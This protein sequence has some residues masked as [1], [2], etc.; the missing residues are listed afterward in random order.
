[1][2]PTGIDGR[3]QSGTDQVFSLLNVIANPE[4]YAKKLKAL[5]DATAEHKKYVDL[6]GPAGDILKLKDD[7]Q[8][9]RAAAADELAAAKA[10]AKKIKSDADAKAKDALEKAQERAKAIIAEAEAIKASAAADKVANQSLS[11][12]LASDLAAAQKAAT[13]A[14]AAAKAADDA[15]ADAIKAKQEADAERDRLVAWHSNAVKE[16]AK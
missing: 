1:M 13:E 8:A 16:L 3:P 12:K 7:A 2:I 4:E 11:T 6:V 14:K 9:D 5:N 10:D 15:K